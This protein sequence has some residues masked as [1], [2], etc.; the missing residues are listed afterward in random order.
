MGITEKLKVQILLLPTFLL[1]LIG[2]SAYGHTG[3]PS[4]SDEEANLAS[5]ARYVSQN[6]SEDVN[7]DSPCD[8]HSQDP[9]CNTCP[10]GH[11]HLQ[12]T[13]LPQE[14]T[15]DV[16]RQPRAWIHLENDRLPLTITFEPALRPPN[17]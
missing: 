16:D 13:S 1:F 17:V 7:E 12:A 15:F 14:K 5:T 8:D 11:C 9:D 3:N 6:A 2:A 10:S 4:Q